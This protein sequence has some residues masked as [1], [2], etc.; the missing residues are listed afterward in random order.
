[1]MILQMHMY[2]KYIRDTALVLLWFDNDSSKQLT[3][4]DVNQN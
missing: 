1:M 2:L 3:I 4:F